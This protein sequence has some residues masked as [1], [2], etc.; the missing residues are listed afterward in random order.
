MALRPVAG[1]ADGETRAAGDQLHLPQRRP[2]GQQMLFTKRIEHHIAHRRIA[3][4]RQRGS[5]R[6]RPLID[7]R[8]GYQ[9]RFTAALAFD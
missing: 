8:P 9:R 1:E 3:D 2:L 7:N 5:D 4:G 6:F